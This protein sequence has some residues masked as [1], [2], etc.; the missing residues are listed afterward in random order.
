FPTGA[1]I[2]G[3]HGVKDAYET[4]RGRVVLRARAEI[5][6]GDTHDKIVITELP[7]GV[8]KADLVKY[9]ADLANEKKIEGIT[10]V[11]DESGRQGMRIV[12]DVR[13]DA[14]A[15]VVLNKLFK[16]TAL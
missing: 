1:I 12:V 15:N 7:Y 13:R 14:N 3:I 8:N 2:Y 4:G 10:Y 16:M 5:E 11:N 6:T 9:I